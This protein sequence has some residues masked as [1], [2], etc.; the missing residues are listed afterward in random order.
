LP[1]FFE[2]WVD[3]K[4]NYKIEYEIQVSERSLIDSKP[5]KKVAILTPSH[6]ELKFRLGKTTANILYKTRPSEQSLT[7]SNLFE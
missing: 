7:S 1:R 4:S 3:L 2:S 5:L 6:E